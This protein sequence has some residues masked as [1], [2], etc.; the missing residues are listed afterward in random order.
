MA[1]K[2]SNILIHC[3]FSTKERRNL[4][5]PE[6]LPRLWK[7]FAGIGRN[8]GIPVLAAGGISNHSHLLIV[9][10][11]DVPVAKAVQVLKANSSRWLHEHGL[12]FAWQEGYGA[13]SVSE[14]N[15]DKVKKYIAQQAEHHRTVSFQEEFLEFLK[16]HRV[17]YDARFIWK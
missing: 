9:L 10:P 8:H 7:Y 6:M 12:E 17:E 16:R 2:Y 15:A 13:F 3:V 11:T 4:I 5:P 1:H 14:S